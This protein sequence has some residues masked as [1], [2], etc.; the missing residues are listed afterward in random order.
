MTPQDGAPCKCRA[1]D[2]CLDEYLEP[3]VYCQRKASNGAPDIPALIVRLRAAADAYDNYAKHDFERALLREAADVLTA[4]SASHEALKER[5][6]WF[7][8]SGGVA[9]HTRVFEEMAKRE[10]A[11]AQV[12]ALTAPKTS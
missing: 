5:V 11:E 7:E 8:K 3:G 1:Q 4:L 2:K 12:A 9:A 6:V 10:A